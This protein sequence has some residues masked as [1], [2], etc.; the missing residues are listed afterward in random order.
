MRAALWKFW[1]CLC[2]SFDVLYA[3][4]GIY[5]V[6]HSNGMFGAD[7]VLGIAL[8]TAFGVVAP[9]VT[10]ALKSEGGTQVN[11]DAANRS[12]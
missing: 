12:R 8:V 10:A 1:Y 7:W 6:H 5:G 11:R 3:A 4:R 9:D 2:V